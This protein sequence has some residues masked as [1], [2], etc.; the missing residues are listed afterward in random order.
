MMGSSKM[1]G[2]LLK[3]D[4]LEGNSLLAEVKI[5]VQPA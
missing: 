1:D 5:G 4:A 2:L 3:P